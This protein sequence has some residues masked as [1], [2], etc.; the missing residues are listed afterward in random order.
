MSDS[1]LKQKGARI[2]LIWAVAIIAIAA[3]LI[4]ALAYGGK[5]A[6]ADDN[7]IAGQSSAETDK[8]GTTDPNGT[9]AVIGTDPSVGITTADDPTAPDGGAG[10]A[11]IPGSTMPGG[12]GTTAGGAQS[13]YGNPAGLPVGS[14]DP[15]PEPTR[16]TV[17]LSIEASTVGRG[18][19]MPARTI[20]IEDGETVFDVLYRE[21]RASG[22]HM[23]SRWT[24]M[25]NSA[26]IEGIDNLYEFDGGH[27]SGWMYRVNGWYP[28]YGASVY[29]LHGG[30]VIEWKYT[31]DLGRDIGGYYATQPGG[32]EE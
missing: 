22:I 9:A 2:A 32:G 23:S 5:A 3:T 7:L 14:A 19:I 4:L 10:N 20:E 6:V 18:Y 31:C 12:S 15:E 13:G 30:E 21:C 17:T 8:A 11:N 28:N 1:F 29:T 26:Y 24:P 16:L 25:Y 27:L